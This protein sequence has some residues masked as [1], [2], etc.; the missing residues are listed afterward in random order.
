MAL[1]K[2]LAGVFRFLLRDKWY[3]SFG[4]CSDDGRNDDERP[5]LSARA[6][7]VEGR[8]SALEA[9][10]DS[11]MQEIKRLSLKIDDQGLADGMYQSG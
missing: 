3:Q 11:M 2:D 10:M 9:T 5:S 1:E 6:G 4:K 8:L 7:I